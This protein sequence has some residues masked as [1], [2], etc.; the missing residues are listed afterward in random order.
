MKKI[1]TIPQ[2]TK[3]NILSINF[4]LA[5]EIPFSGFDKDSLQ[6]M[7][8]CSIISQILVEKKQQ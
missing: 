2:N 6:A 5:I 3:T 8:Q 1:L 4:T 7:L